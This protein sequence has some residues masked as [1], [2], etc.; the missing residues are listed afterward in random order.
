MIIQFDDDEAR[1]LYAVLL[2]KRRNTSA[3]RVR[4]NQAKDCASWQSESRVHRESWWL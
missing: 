2:E 3:M 1:L 4:P